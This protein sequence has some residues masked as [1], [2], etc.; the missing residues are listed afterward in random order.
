MKK[1]KKEKSTEILIYRKFPFFFHEMIIS[2]FS[3]HYLSQGLI[4]SYENP[5]IIFNI[6]EIIFISE[7]FP[8]FSLLIPFLLLS[9]F[10]YINPIKI[11]QYP[12][13][14]KKKKI[15][16]RRETHLISRVAIRAD[17]KTFPSYFPCKFYIL[18]NKPNTKA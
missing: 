9:S 5:N 10:P 13:R 3:L 4:L 8:F 17:V 14:R 6:T 15:L 18:L 2:F 16:S 1:K 11:Q 7:I 12:V